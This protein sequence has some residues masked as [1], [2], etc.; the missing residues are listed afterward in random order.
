[1]STPSR[2]RRLGVA[3]LTPLVLLLSACGAQIS[4]TIHDDDTFELTMLVWDD[5]GSGTLTKDTCTESAMGGSSGFPSG[6]KPTYTFTD[7]NG[8]PACEIKTAKAPIS[9][10]N[11]DLTITHAD[12]RYTF[13]M[14]HSAIENMKKDPQTAAA[15][16]LFPVELRVTFPGEVTEVSGNGTKEGNTAVWSKMAEETGDLKAVGLDGKPTAPADKDG[17]SAAGSS[18]TSS[19]SSGSSST[20]WIVL[21]VVGALVAVGVIV[22]VVV[23]SRRRSK[24]QAAAQAAY[25]SSY[26]PQQGYPQPAAQGDYQQPDQS[27]YQPPQY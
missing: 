3:L 11:K 6:T 10:G 17:S 24:R 14:S 20:L 22:A 2:S 27:A 7:H 8:A 16:N 12:G 19:T 4:F 15:L 9:S 21:G 13:L 25:P 26:A 5:T 1:M 23:A 18:S